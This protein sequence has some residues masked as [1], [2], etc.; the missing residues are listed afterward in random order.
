M[1][2]FLFLCRHSLSGWVTHV[3]WT[4]PRLA[5]GLPLPPDSR[6]FSGTLLTLS[7]ARHHSLDARLEIVD[8]ERLRHEIGR[9]ESQPEYAIDLVVACT[10]DHDVCRSLS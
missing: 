6:R 10:A 7:G 8:V 2:T 9:A 3:G 5:L 1:M 4:L